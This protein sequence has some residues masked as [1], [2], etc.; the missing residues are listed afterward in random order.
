MGETAETAANVGAVM[1]MR[2]DHRL[3]GLWG[4]RPA[5]AA[6]DFTGDADLAGAMDAI[7]WPRAR[8][9]S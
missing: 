6:V 9:W 4:R 8:P 7:L 1:T 2:A 5:A 3:L